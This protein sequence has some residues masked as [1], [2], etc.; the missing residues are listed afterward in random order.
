MD[1][2]IKALQGHLTNG[3]F[4]SAIVSIR[5]LSELRDNLEQLLE[6]GLLNRDFYD[7]IVSRLDLYWDFEPPADLPG[8]Q[9]IILV[10]APVL[11][12]RVPVTVSG[13]TSCVIIPPNYLNST[14]KEMKD[15]LSHCSQRYGLRF[16]EAILPEK[17]LAV[18]S[19]LA[20]YGRN[21]IAYIDG[22]GSYF[23]LRTFFSDVPCPPDHWW[24]MKMMDLCDSCSGC[25][26]MC[27]TGAISEGRFLIRCERCLTFYNE[28]PE[29]FPEWIDSAWH[30]C[31]IGCMICQ[32]IC[33]ANR[34]FTDWIDGG[35][36]F[37]EE[38]TMM[39]WDGIPLDKLP[40]VMAEKLGKLNMIDDYGLLRRNL[41]VLING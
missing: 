10:A 4:K 2:K 31:L 3:G 23:R 9:S 41:R 16:V 27:P 38:E 8:I 17:L 22:W 36:A 24:E 30:N 37:T 15:I 5:H 7:E 13:K 21:N 18:R 28:G 12:V 39:I 14:D 34:K 26:K 6:S 40:R 19:G 1:K 33:P 25:R 29:D 32:D 35:E 11:K 20:R